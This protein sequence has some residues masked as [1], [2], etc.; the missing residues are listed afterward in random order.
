ML[1][2]IDCRAKIIADATINKDLTLSSGRSLSPSTV[3]DY[4]NVHY[5]GLTSAYSCI[6]YIGGICD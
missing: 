2:L 4:T 5:H 6:Y 3:S 1:V